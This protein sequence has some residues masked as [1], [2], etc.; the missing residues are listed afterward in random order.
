MDMR[1]G[2]IT[3][4]RVQPAKSGQGSGQFQAAGGGQFPLQRQSGHNIVL[5]LLVVTQF[6]QRNTQ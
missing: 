2:K 4:H 1:P 3:R 5:C 6:K